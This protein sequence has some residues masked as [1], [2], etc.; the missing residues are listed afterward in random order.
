MDSLDRKIL[1]ILQEDS[2]KTM[3]EI[4][5]LTSSSKST[6]SMRIQRLTD[7]EIIKQYRISVDLEKIGGYHMLVFIKCFPSHATF[8]KNFLG[9]C[10]NVI[11]Y[12]KVI[13]AFDYVAE[14]YAGSSCVMDE[15]LTHLES[16]GEIEKLS[17]SLVTKKGVIPMESPTK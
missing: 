16:F 15:C 6:V 5:E 4:A 14:I 9:S 7:Q 11:R 3:S 12:F 8:A 17:V 13:G 2:R 1:T 10:D